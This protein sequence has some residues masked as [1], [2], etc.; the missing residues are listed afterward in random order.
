MPQTPLLDATDRRIIR[1]LQRNGR[2]TNL[3]LAEEVGLSPS[4]CL[5][6]LE[7]PPPALDPS[8]LAVPPP[9]SSRG[10]GWRR[11]EPQEEIKR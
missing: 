1:A 10:G 7:F 6:R 3:D 4:P 2:M 9:L 8:V 5:R 11:T